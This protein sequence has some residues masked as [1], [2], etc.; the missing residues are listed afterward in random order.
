MRLETNE[1]EMRTAAKWTAANETERLAMSAAHAC[2]ILATT[3][4][5][6]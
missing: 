1:A 5:P 6:V 2:L 4:A 3:T